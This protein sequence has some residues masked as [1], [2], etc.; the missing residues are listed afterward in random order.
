MELFARQVD[1]APDAIAVAGGGRQL[2]YAELAAWSDRL[3]AHLLAAGV[4]AGEFVGLLGERGL[5]APV[6]MLGILK[7]GGVY[8]P[9]DRADPVA[10]LRM[11]VDELA[12][13]RTVTMPGC[14]GLLDRVPG[15]AVA[16]T[17]A[18]PAVS[19][20][21]IDA[22]GGAA[23][24]VMFTSGS[25]GTP[26]G[27]AVPHR[28]VA[29]LVVDTDFVRITPADSVANTGHH[30][31]DA[32]V[33]EIWGA[34]L[35]GARLVIVEQETLLDP[36]RL[37]SALEQERIS[38]LWLSAGVFHQCARAIPTM[39][40]DLR[41]LIS[42]GDVLLP[43]LVR[44]VLRAG[45]PGSLIN[46]Y[47]PT[48][49]TTFSTTH[50]VTAVPAGTARVPIGRP[51]ANSTCY[52]VRAD[53]SLADVAEEG[54]IVVGGDGVALGYVNHP[55]LTA[56]RFV[57]D[58]YGR[59]PG[60]R[61]FRTGDRGRWLPEGVLD[62]LGRTD[63]MIKLRDFRIELDEVE[64]V[65]ATHPQLG[66]AAVTTTGD[67]PLT[68]TMVAFYTP[69]GTADAPTPGELRAFLAQ[70]L[71]AFMLP[72]RYLPVQ[73]LPLTATG[74]VDRALLERGTGGVAPPAARP[75]RRPE[76][77]VQV[78]LAQLWTETLDVDEVTLDDS[79]FE[80]G[81]NSLLAA[82]V[83][84]RLRDTFG[85]APEQGRFL[86]RRLLADP[87][88]EA[89]AEAVQQARINLLRHDEVGHDVDFQR[90]AALTVPVRVEPSAPDPDGEVLLTGATG[91]L[92]SYLLRE[93]LNATRARVH[94]LVR[95]PD[96]AG[97][98]HRLSAAQRRY[99]LGDLPRDRVVP[100]VGDLGLP[101]LGLAE[102]AFD[103]YAREL[104][105]IMHAA[106][107][108]NFTY[109]YA[110]L[111]KVTV[112]GTRE[113]IRLAG[114]H[115]GVP[116]HFVSTLAVLAGFAGTRRRVVTEDLPPAYPERLYMG[117]PETKWVAETM[118]RHAAD[119]GLPVSVY[120]PYEI[121]GD[122]RDGQ[123]NLES[124]TC[125][126]FRIIADTGA[127]PDI[128]LPLDLVPVDLLARQMVH[129]ART[130][131]AAT[132][133]YHLANDRP[134]M[135]A[136]MADR[137][138]AHG[139]P[140]RTLPLDRWVADAVRLACDRPEHPFTPFIPLWVDR[141]PASG[142]VVKQMYFGSLFP[143]FGR[144]NAR[145]ALAGA[146]LELPPVDAG[147]LDHYVRYFQRCGFLPP[148]PGRD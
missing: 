19:P 6:G 68:R 141:S 33:F 50:R 65:L 89:C 20:P 140:V 66:A 40:R 98:L 104:G 35:N 90:E 94:C 133:T 10:R 72:G 101:L 60:A 24:Y 107:Y 9:L 18:G 5:T 129:I 8:V 55:E 100:L 119:A 148:P 135:L 70:Q 84:A 7:A 32:S 86:T 38:V 93:L 125:A 36:H 61:L 77:P 131:T 17:E 13:S 103:R 12:I 111:A 136:D 73:R 53:G 51:I 120:R 64:A 31:F 105:L 63:R 110:H 34:L 3:A 48:E 147:L 52:V 118:L 139:Y 142:L 27:V 45:A 92:G 146:D 137:L 96:V 47:G 138:R 112:A 116:V 30:S 58:P 23:A 75:G 76:T 62:F 57:P 1:R 102:E 122:L 106:A 113:V 91:F 46:G 79:F 74:K 78:G 130:R 11:L 121:S 132:S 95:A 49:N 39:F 42:G 109:P 29:R 22:D 80:L 4:R 56:E 41:C 71:P 67:H 21:P 143:E 115:R 117:Y 88:L 25:T 15:H 59:R 37:A 145:A 14:G 108:V 85:I 144:D 16:D 124:A 114:R 44:E 128:D 81:G 54:E 82:R 99:G 126:L 28:A 127:V 83:F 43:D 134:A 2:T 87:S 97:A 26:K 69:R 123:W